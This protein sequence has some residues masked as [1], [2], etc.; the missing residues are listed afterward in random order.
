MI[1]T[2][3]PLGRRHPIPE[4]MDAHATVPVGAD[5]GLG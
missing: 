4:G 3:L 1:A 2:G 5:L